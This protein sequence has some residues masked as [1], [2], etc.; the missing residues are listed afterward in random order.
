MSSG[1]E[2]AIAIH[3]WKV[4]LG[5][6]ATFLGFKFQKSYS[7]K[8]ERLKNL[9]TKHTELSEAHIE[10]RGRLNVLEDMHREY[11]E[12]QKKINEIHTTVEVIKTEVKHLKE[13]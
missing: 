6:L 5:A 3:W 1:L 4:C 13:G 9:E 2:A 11:V 10:Q 12:S 7:E 8:E